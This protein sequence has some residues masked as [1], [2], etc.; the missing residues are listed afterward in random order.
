MTQAKA[1]LYFHMQGKT[2]SFGE[3][4]SNGNFRE[5]STHEAA[6]EVLQEVRCD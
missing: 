2:Q 1:I 4:I 6:I 5:N 3:R